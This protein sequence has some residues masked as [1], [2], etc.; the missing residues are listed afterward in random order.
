M[1]VGNTVRMWRLARLAVLVC[2]PVALTLSVALA[3]ADQSQV[4]NAKLETRSVSQDLA[5]T[6][7]QIAAASSQRPW[8][9]YE[10][11]AVAAAEICCGNGWHGDNTND[12]CGVCNLEQQ[13]NNH[14]VES[15]HKTVQFEAAPEVAILLRVEQKH[16]M[17]IRMASSNCTLDGGGLRAVWLDG[18][19][20]ADSVALLTGYVDGKSNDEHHGGDLTEPA[21]AAI[22]QHADPA[23]DRVFASFVAPDQPILAARKNFFLA[24]RGAR[25]IWSGG[26]GEN[27]ARAIPAPTCAR[28]FPSRFSSATNLAR[29]TT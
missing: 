20:P 21:L 14:H 25:Q 29:S 3:H 16:V 19:K 10:V 9:V 12:M 5:G 18:V 8:I 2:S 13:Q 11:P 7:Q 4:V 15:G 28:K 24:R 22:A 17:R 26:S 1:R 23:A 27:G 6:V